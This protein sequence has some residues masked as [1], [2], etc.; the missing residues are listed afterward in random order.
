MHN[1]GRGYS[2]IYHGEWKRKA[3]ELFAPLEATKMFL[4]VRM[5]EGVTSRKGS[6]G[7]MQTAAWCY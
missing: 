4:V 1:Y 7:K 5:G 2:N 6:S 3:L